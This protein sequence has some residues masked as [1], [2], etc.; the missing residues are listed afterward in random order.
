LNK[1]GEVEG[2]FEAGLEIFR[3]EPARRYRRASPAVMKIWVKTEKSL[4]IASIAA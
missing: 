4:A 1:G 3:E 2:I